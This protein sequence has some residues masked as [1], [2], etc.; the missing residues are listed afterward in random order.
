M[1]WEIVNVNG[2]F[3]H[4]LMYLSFVE[5]VVEQNQMLCNHVE[6]V[7]RNF[8]IVV[9]Y[10]LMFVRLLLVRLELNVVLHLVELIFPKR[11]ICGN[12]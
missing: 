6:I 2:I 7:D 8:V 1:M 3:L 12:E 11:D 5:D 10:Y 4:L 9:E